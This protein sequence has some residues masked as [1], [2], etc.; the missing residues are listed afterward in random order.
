MNLKTKRQIVK[1]FYNFLRLVF[2]LAG[3]EGI[4]LIR[5]AFEEWRAVKTHKPKP[6]KKRKRRKKS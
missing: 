1:A 6:A 4:R 5:Q 2:N 3:E